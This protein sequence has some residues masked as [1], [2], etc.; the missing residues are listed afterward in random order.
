MRRSLLFMAG[1][2]GKPDLAHAMWTD[3][4]PEQKAQAHVALRTLTSQGTAPEDADLIAIVDKHIS[5]TMRPLGL[6]APHRGGNWAAEI[7]TWGCAPGRGVAKVGDFIPG[8][9]SWVPARSATPIL[10]LSGL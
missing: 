2:A 7:G 1:L 8:A 10:P 9:A 5:R 6:E 3:I 4:P